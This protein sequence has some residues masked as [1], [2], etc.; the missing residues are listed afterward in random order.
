MLMSELLVQP[1]TLLP[2]TAPHL[3]RKT[4]SKASPLKV[5]DFCPASR[6]SSRSPAFLGFQR[7]DVPRD[8]A[9]AAGEPGIHFSA[10]G[11]RPRGWRATSPAAAFL[12]RPVSARRSPRLQAPRATEPSPGRGSAASGACSSPP[13][14]PLPP[15]SRPLALPGTRALPAA[16]VLHNFSRRSRGRGSGPARC[17]LRLSHLVP[18]AGPRGASGATWPL[19]VPFCTP[20]FWSPRPP[21]AGRR[22][23]GSWPFLLPGAPGAAE[24][25]PC[26]SSSSSWKPVVRTQ[27]LRWSRRGTRGTP[28]PCKQVSQPGGSRCWGCANLGSTPGTPGCA[29]GAPGGRLPGFSSS[30]ALARPQ[31]CA[32][33]GDRSATLVQ[34]RHRL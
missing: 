3:G 5:H 13:T 15:P 30:V 22:C 34:P 20:P 33:R 10:L 12:A 4:R 19:A 16:Q 18:R 25:S 6:R 17:A 11:A 27:A 2:S 29:A 24:P 26:P 31:E 14:R 21:R 7:C 9:P 1:G 28:G 8:R 32:G 23:S